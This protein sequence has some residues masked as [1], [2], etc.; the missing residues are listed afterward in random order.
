MQ[1]LFGAILSRVHAWR[2]SEFER[3]IIASCSLSFAWRKFSCSTLLHSHEL[4]ES[5][6]Q[7]ADIGDKKRFQL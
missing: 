5:N 3:E 6:F 1:R 2:E 7:R 4:D